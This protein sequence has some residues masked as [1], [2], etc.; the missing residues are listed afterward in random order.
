MSWTIACFC[1]THYTTPPGRC[2]ACGERLEQYE[3]PGLDV[4]ASRPAGDE[5]PNWLP[6]SHE[7]LP[8]C[9]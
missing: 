1:G 8:Y 6:C 9:P 4:E 7:S 5:E 2:P 3:E